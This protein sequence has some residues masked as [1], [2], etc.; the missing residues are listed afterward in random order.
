MM[1]NAW[2]CGILLTGCLAD[3]PREV[4][5]P[6]LD[7]RAPFPELSSRLPITPAKAQP[8]G[9]GFEEALAELEPLEPEVEEAEATPHRDLTVRNFTVE[10]PFGEGWSNTGPSAGGVLTIHYQPVGAPDPLAIVYTEP[11]TGL[12]QMS[13]S[14]ELRRF[15]QKIDRQLLP[16]IALL[17][18][19]DDNTPFAPIDWAFESTRKSFT[20]WRWVG[21]NSHGVELRLARVTG[22]WIHNAAPQQP[23]QLQDLL[24]DL[25]VDLGKLGV[26]LDQLQDLGIDL[27]QQDLGADPTNAPINRTPPHAVPA[28]MVFGHARVNDTNGF[29]IAIVCNRTGGCPVASELS[30]LLDTIQ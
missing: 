21:K 10:V 27:D 5:F 7:A 9:T 20:G 13:P 2:L 30:A 17:S 18:L 23:A 3:G 15:L 6:V 4:P 22:S 8:D 19:P 16:S 29:H 11:F 14:A 12:A 28:W 1:R 24:G 26:D 25:P